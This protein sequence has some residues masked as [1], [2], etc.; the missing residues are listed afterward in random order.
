MPDK[1][2]TMLVDAMK[3][4]L[5]GYLICAALLIAV[6]AALADGTLDGFVLQGIMIFFAPVGRLSAL[7]RAR[8]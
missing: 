7:L 2:I 6:F 1:L 4:A 5:K 3:D 8:P